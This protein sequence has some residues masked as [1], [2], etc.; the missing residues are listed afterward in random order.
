MLRNGM[1]RVT[2]A[3]DDVAG[4]QRCRDVIDYVI[5]SKTLQLTRDMTSH[6][7]SHAGNNY[8]KQLQ[9]HGDVYAYLDR[10][11]DVISV[12]G[13]ESGRE[14]AFDELKEYI[15]VTREQLVKRISLQDT[16]SVMKELF[17]LYGFTLQQLATQINASQ[18]E[19]NLRRRE[20]YFRGTEVSLE[21][22]NDVI[23]ELRM[24]LGLQLAEQDSAELPDCPICFTS[25]EVTSQHHV[26]E[27]CAHVYCKECVEGL[28]A[29]SVKDRQFPV[30][31]AAYNCGQDFCM[32]DIKAIKGASSKHLD[33]VIK[34]AVENL[35]AQSDGAYKYCVTPNCEAIYRSTK[36]GGTEKN[37]LVCY[38]CQV[39]LCSTCH[40]Q[41]HTGKSCHVH[42]GIAD[43]SDY[44]IKLYMRRHKDRVVI[45]QKCGAYIERIDGCNKMTCSQCKSHFC[46][47]CHQLFPTESDVYDHQS[48]C[49]GKPATRHDDVTDDGDY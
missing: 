37:K 14:R 49:P 45:C 16:P 1:V 35:V 10:R 38:K 44:G 40:V 27:L 11:A 39:L 32:A 25:V 33:D 31:C 28:L 36:L 6:F 17:K 19:L 46:W 15:A 34:S 5:G 4:L 8:L 26:L 2:G 13:S 24:R 20:L 3:A 47:V 21:Q 9:R 7:L 41:Y 43:D 18:L 23:A 30:T 29:S 12:Y 42:Q 22:L 48:S